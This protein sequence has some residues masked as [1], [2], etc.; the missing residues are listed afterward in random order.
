MLNRLEPSGFWDSGDEPVPP[1]HALPLTRWID[2]LDGG[3]VAFLLRATSEGARAWLERDRIDSH[4]RA[5]MLEACVTEV[6]PL[7]SDTWAISMAVAGGI[8][9]PENAMHVHMVSQRLAK[10]LAF[11]FNGGETPSFSVY[12]VAGMRTAEAVQE[13]IREMN[14][15]LEIIVNHQLTTQFQPIVTL[16]DGKVY[17]YEALIRGP[18]HTPLRRPGALF[19]A[20]AKAQMIAWFDMACL[21]QCFLQAAS[22]GLRHNLF[23]NVEA[24]GLDSINKHDRPLA[25]RVRDAGLRPDQIVIEIT[26]RQ[27]LDDF[28]RLTEAISSLREQGFKLAVDDVGA[29]YNS[30][31]LITELQPDFVKIDRNLVK[32]LDV[33]GARRGLLATLVR[34]AR[35]IG[36]AVIGEGAETWDEL[37][38]LIDLD[39][40]YGQGYLLGKPADVFCGVRKDLRTDIAARHAQRSQLTMGRGVKVSGLMRKGCTLAIDTPLAEAARRFARD[41]SL[42]SI[43]IIE[44]ESIRGL[45]MRQAL[46][47]ILSM[48]NTAHALKMLPDEQV[49][50]WMCSDYIT[51]SPDTELGVVMRMVARRLSIS[52]DSDIVISEAGQKY[53][54]VL[55]VRTL[56]ESL[57]TAHQFGSRY[58]DSLSGLPNRVVLEHTI[59]ERLEQHQPTGLLRVDVMYLEAYNR[60]FGTAH[61]DELIKGLVEILQEVAPVREGN[62]LTHLGGDDFVVVTHP[63]N[64]ERLSSEVRTR[65]SALAPRL[66]PYETSMDGYMEIEEHGR[67]NRVPLCSLAIAGVTGRGSRLTGVMQALQVLDTI[68]HSV[69]ASGTGGCAIDVVQARKAA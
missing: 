61:G 18:H 62:V 39:V 34:Y 23:V 42:T 40:T 19:H 63:D 43:V 55:P 10:E 65:F 57:S 44:N 51:A 68:L 9:L 59:K 45:L 36:T 13:N 21:E 31:Q 27:T 28:P 32:N 53:M 3:K 46:D 50:G 64:V 6:W 37:S 67:I 7:L 35:Q 14:A 38:T 26:E 54:G 16:S 8:E 20:A 1:A 4:L 30:L 49:G 69:Q 22:I 17:G 56:M 66:F 52:L 15:L 25:L 33:N 2:A 29:G 41:P 47:H 5:V 11:D 24:E 48:A 60:K 12:P 58:S